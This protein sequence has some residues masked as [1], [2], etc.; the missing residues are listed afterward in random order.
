MKKVFL[1]AVLV[2][3]A[4]AFTSCEKTEKDAQG[5]K[6]DLK[7]PTDHEAVKPGSDIHFD[8]VL[9]DDTALKSYKINIHGAFDGH[10]HS[11]E[12]RSA[13]DA[14][15]F[16]KTWTE[17][18]FIKLGDEPII[19]KKTANLHHHHIV[20]PKEINGKPIKE[21]DYHFM[22]YCTDEAGNESFVAREIEISH[23][24]EEH[25]HHHH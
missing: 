1:A 5:P 23:S 17:A 12:A 16:E 4:I 19:G 21:G 7:A 9:S 8:A 14:V 11:A 18:D 22:I 3:G 24:A 25:E 15:A 10:T 2:A 13:D 20:I 6:I